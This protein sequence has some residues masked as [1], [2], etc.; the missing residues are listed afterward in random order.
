MTPRNR[1]QNSLTRGAAALSILVLQLAFLHQAASGIILESSS[2]STVDPAA[3]ILK[4]LGDRDSLLF[5]PFNRYEHG[6]DPNDRIDSRQLLSQALDLMAQNVPLPGEVISEEELRIVGGYVVPSGRYK[7][8][9]SLR[10]GNG[11]HYCGGT[12]IAPGVV[13]TAAHCV[14][15]EDSKPRSPPVDLDMQTLT[16]STTSG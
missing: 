2:S 3:D 16:S 10:D 15:Q 5:E 12:L 9:A 13:L 11:N 1:S 14:N 8:M 7:F 6:S 4:S